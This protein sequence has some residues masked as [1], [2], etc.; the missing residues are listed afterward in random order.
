M[1][2]SFLL[3]LIILIYVCELLGQSCLKYFGSNRNKP[4]YYFLALLFYSI[5]CYLLVMSY[6]YKGIGIVNIIWSGVSVLVVLTGG[7]LMFG[8]EI[9]NMDKIGV[10][11]ILSGI[12]FVLYEGDHPIEK[13]YFK[14]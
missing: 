10:L 14:E 6:Q 7:Y 5:V 1:N 11:L 3:I 2:S 4:H 13:K 8:E 12:F 9:T